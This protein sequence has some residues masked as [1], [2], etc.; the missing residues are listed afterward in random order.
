MPLHADGRRRSVDCLLVE[1]E[2]QVATLLLG[3]LDRVGFRVDWVTSV[4]AAVGALL[5]RPY[6]VVLLDIV[7]KQGG[8]RPNQDGLDVAREMRRRGIDTPFVVMTAFPTFEHGCE[9]GELHPA[10]VLEKGADPRPIVE[11][12]QAAAAALRTSAD[13]IA[14]VREDL[15]AIDLS[16]PDAADRCSAVLFRAIGHPALTL[17]QS[18]ALSRECVVLSRRAVVPDRLRLVDALN[19]PPLVGH[20]DVDR[21]LAVLASGPVASNAALSAAGGMS[22]RAIRE[23]L[24]THTG[25]GP[26]ECRCVARGTRFVGGLVNTHDDI[27]HCADAAGYRYGRQSVEEC[28]RLFGRVPTEIRRL[29]KR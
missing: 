21:I 19:T 7:L 27:G 13:P 6:S 28:R 25:H 8:G 1:D 12:C 14:R 4:S 9:A 26:T 15:G 18:V 23:L 3:R 22:V 24:K 10:A 16:R 11:A 5:L 17:F 29:L 2:P 20:P